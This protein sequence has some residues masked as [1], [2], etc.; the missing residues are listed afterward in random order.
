MSFLQH[1]FLLL[2]AC[3]LAG[4]APGRA[5]STEFQYLS[6]RDKDHTV[7][8]QFFCTKGQNS[9]K[10]TTIPVPSNW[11]LQGFGNYNYGNDKWATHA[12]EQGRYKH[13]FRVNPAWRHKQIFLVFEGSMTD[14]EVKVNGQSAGPV[15]QGAFTRFKYNVT[16]LLQFGQDNLLE[17][18]VSK[19][20]ANESV[21]RAERYADFWIFGGI[22][23]PVYLEALPQQ[24]IGRTAI[25]ARADGSFAVDVYLQHIA[26]PATV[27]ARIR[28]RSGEPVGV[29]V[30]VPVAAGQQQVR[31][32]TRVENPRLWSAEFP[33]LYRVEVRLKDAQA[34]LHAVKEKFGFRTVE[35]RP[36]DGLYVNG[37]RV[38][39]K[40]VNRHSFW[41][42]SG[43]TMSR[44][45]SVL[46]VNL[47]KDMN[48]N[49]V[50]MSHYPPDKHFLEVCDSLGLFVLDELTGWQKAYDTQVG[51]KLLKELVV[52]DVNHP[53]IIIWDNGNEGGNNFELDDD[54]ALYDPQARPVIHPW[55]VFRHTDTQHYKAYDCCNGTLFHGRE[56]FFPTEFLHGVFDGGHGAGLDDY[57]NLMLQNPLA[58]GGFLWSF[59]DEGVVRTDQDNKIDV[60][61]SSA[62]DGI[63]GPYREKEGSYFTIREVWSPVYIGQEFLPASFRGT[64]AVE[65]R[66]HYTNLNQCSFTWKLVNFPLPGQSQAGA[67]TVRTGTAPAPDVAPGYQRGELQLNLPADF[68]QYD[69][70]YLTATDPHGRE[71]FTWSW[72]LKTPQQFARQLIGQTKIKGR[73]KGVALQETEAQ[74]IV[75]ANGVEVRFNRQDGT[76]AGVRNARKSIS[77]RNGP[78]LAAGK[79]QFKEMTY[80]REGDDVVIENS[81]E[82]EV[83]KL[84][85]RLLANGWLRLEYEYLPKGYYDYLGITFDYPE[86]QVT[87]LKFL[88]DGPYRVWKNRMKGTQFGVWQK[89]YNNTVTG[90]SWQYPEFKGYHANLHWAVV[91]N[92]EYPFTVVSESPDMFLRLFTPQAAK[93]AYNNNTVP[94]FP[95]GDISFLNGI[96]PIGDKFLKPEQ[97]GPQGQQ[98]QFF[99]HG[100]NPK[101]LGGVLYFDFGAGIRK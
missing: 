31:L 91:E 44:E 43:R 9:G 33:N 67:S 14:T 69:G 51:R 61:G 55:N 32:T 39:L 40:G 89:P 35:L 41:P 71:I 100:S 95:A 94:A 2:A 21:N 30:A 7:A 64:L 19:K 23:R 62:P 47:M 75:S 66:Y 37:R 63:V 81:Y 50:R 83:K 49:A 6:G 12:D 60:K 79:N 15:H 5:Q 29:P 46:D 26:G 87:G 22:Y 10:W 77:F 99:Y 97:L 8:W 18:T 96:S 76:I 74:L 59:S 38:R 54:F 45:L 13:T 16:P 92:K 56:V 72:P 58:A 34:T 52:R 86:A 65:N 4:M 88:G 20:S 84:Q 1:T 78:V 57:W 11:E 68:R 28:T 73:S 98:N 82:G 48:M 70:L 93:G 90:E 101:N 27:E 53:S 17:V 42:T 3:L 85:Y 24:F 80:R 25:D 36:N